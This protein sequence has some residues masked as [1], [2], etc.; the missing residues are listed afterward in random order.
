M[1]AARVLAMQMNVDLNQV[2]PTGPQGLVTV[3]D[4]KKM[5]GV[6]TTTTT[7]VSSTLLA[8]KTEVLHGVRRIM[9][10]AMMQSHREI[11]PVTIIEDADIT[12]LPPKSDLTALLIQAMVTAAK[13]EPAMN[14]WFD[15]KT[16]ERKLFSEINIGIALDTT[17]G[18]YR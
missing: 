6:I 12:D 7:P 2:N 8:G 18:L 10:Q 15:G 17:E 5:I 16:L 3:D 1:P 13:V 11:V 4:V 14:A 9:A